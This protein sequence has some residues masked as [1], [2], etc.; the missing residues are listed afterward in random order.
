MLRFALRLL[1]SLLVGAVGWTPG[2]VSM[3]TE[4]APVTSYCFDRELDDGRPRH[5]C[6]RLAS[7]TQDIC[8]A[9]D[10]YAQLWHLP[11]GYFARL[12]W[13][14][15]HFD[16]NAVSP[17]GAEGIA[18]FMPG[19]G[20]LQGLRNPYDPAEA[21]FRSARY[22][23][24]LRQKF[25]NLG[26]AAAAYN[27]GE[28]AAA[29]VIAGTG[30]LAAETLD[31]VET[32]TG[33]PVTQWLS[34]EVSGADYTLDPGKPFQQSCVAMAENNRVRKFTPPT[35][36]VRPW[37]IQVAQF[38]SAATARRAFSRIQASFPKVIGGE[39]LMLVAKR[40]PNFG[41]AL[42]FTAEIGRD[43]RAAAQK[44]CDALQRAGGACIVVRN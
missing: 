9:I 13:Q 11:T 10:R 33:V 37:G 17:V 36:I 6:I 16:A 27:G 35:A 38:F 5:V 7:Y 18:Q 39:E 44:L 2:G 22:L 23:D 20:R 26:L 8:T 14:E 41:P 40:N 42:R 4:A 1:L 21:L 15:S 34:G 32:I 43:S 3:A 31:Y 29:R 19:T 28:G 24:F 25:G 12:I 30:Y